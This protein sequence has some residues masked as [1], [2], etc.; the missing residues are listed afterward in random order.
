VWERLDDP[1]RQR[2]L[3]VGVITSN[4]AI[5]FGAS[6]IVTWL[7]RLIAPTSWR[8]MTNGVSLLLLGTGLAVW[9]ITWGVGLYVIRGD[10]SLAE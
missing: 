7:L 6:G 2:L 9:A 4:A 1:S 8:H 3:K 10:R 5:I